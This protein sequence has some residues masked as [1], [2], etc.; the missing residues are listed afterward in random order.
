[1]HHNFVRCSFGWLW[2]H[3]R[4]ELITGFIVNC[5]L[6]IVQCNWI[7]QVTGDKMGKSKKLNVQLQNDKIQDDQL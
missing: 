1:M 3:Y 6:Y 4:L 2:M 5:K 7:S